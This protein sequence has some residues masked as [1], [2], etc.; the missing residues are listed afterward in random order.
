MDTWQLHR[1]KTTGEAWY[2]CQT[3]RNE[4]NSLNDRIFMM[5]SKTQLIT[6][7]ALDQFWNVHSNKVLRHDFSMDLTKRL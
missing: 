6:L 4:S 5:I 2:M 7:I 1:K 3:H